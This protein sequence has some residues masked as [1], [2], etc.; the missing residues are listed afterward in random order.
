MPSGRGRSSNASDPRSIALRVLSATARDT[1]LDRA[2]GASS[3]PSRHRAWVQELTYGV[4][5]L[6][7][8]LDHLLGGHLE[9]GV[10]SLPPD[11]RILLRMGAYQGLYMGA[12]PAY[13]AVSETVGAV[14]RTRGATLAGL[15]NAV[16]RR[17]IEAGGDP[18]LFPDPGTD[19]VGYLSTWGSHP[20][21]L[22]ERWL[23]VVQPATVMAWVEQNNRV[24]EICLRPYRGSIEEAR[25]R[26][27][28]SGVPVEPS[29]EGLCLVL[30]AGADVGK[31]LDVTGG[32]VQDPAAARVSAYAL[33]HPGARVA[34]LCAAPGG[35]SLAISAAGH[36]V[37]AAD[38]SRRRLELL[39]DSVK[40]LEAPIP[41]VRARA[42]EPPFRSLPAV[43]L[44]VPCTG[45][46]TLRRHPDAR[47]KIDPMR[48]ASLVE[49]QRELLDGAAGAVAPGGLLVYATCSLEPEEN[50]DQ[51]NEF[52]AR[53]PEFRL[54]GELNPD[55]SE[56]P[57]PGQESGMLRL[58]PDR[59][60][61]DGAFAA[62]LRRR[63]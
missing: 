53:N 8:R 21:W 13:A 22:V 51:V 1:A 63:G 37:V 12:V 24:P 47:W 60:G 23:R 2:L 30:P 31:A 59:T 16:L 38:P 5:R 40:R 10:D 34:D 52:L 56:A 18:T 61:Y 49:L 45:T 26:L 39:R 25:A 43:L 42:Q 58:S 20:R 62:R 46:G 15:A 50:E 4:V 44:D 55:G 28:E 14:R 6:Q 11:V 36:P 9:R 35:K 32:Y 57:P 29:T 3:V 17:V 54:G 48:L 7:G 41:I 19:L 33:P 27:A